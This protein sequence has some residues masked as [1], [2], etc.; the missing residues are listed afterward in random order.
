MPHLH[1]LSAFLHSSHKLRVFIFVKL[2]DHFNSPFDI[3]D[4]SVTC[5]L[6]VIFMSFIFTCFII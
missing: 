3:F 1:F 2:T 5:Y 6:N 4:C